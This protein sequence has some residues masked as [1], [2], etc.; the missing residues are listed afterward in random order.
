MIGA[1]PVEQ[2]AALIVGEPMVDLATKYV[3]SSS[4]LFYAV[5][6]GLPARRSSMELPHVESF[7][8]VHLRDPREFDGSEP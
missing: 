6:K 1:M 3:L 5:A 2:M 7:P 8:G 4:C